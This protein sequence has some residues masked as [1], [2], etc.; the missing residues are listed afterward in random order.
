MRQFR[1]KLKELMS[2]R[3]DRDQ[4]LQLSVVLFICALGLSLA[5]SGIIHLII[6]AVI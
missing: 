3:L 6:G 5:I 4:A 1:D 2:T